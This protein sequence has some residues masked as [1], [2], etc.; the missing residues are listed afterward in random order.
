MCDHPPSTS[1]RISVPFIQKIE[2]SIS[3]FHHCQ[4]FDHRPTLSE[5]SGAYTCGQNLA[6]M[7]ESQRAKRQICPGG[8]SVAWWL[9]RQISGS[10]AA[11]THG[12]NPPLGNTT[13]SSSFSGLSVSSLPREYG[14]LQKVIETKD[15]VL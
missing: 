12:Q 3:G 14:F 11:L 5:T 4:I 13:P 7:G 10:F 2:L 9:G 1:Q 15:H 6:G 8:G